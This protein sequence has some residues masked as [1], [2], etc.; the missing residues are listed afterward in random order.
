MKM[1]I[2]VGD[3][4]TFGDVPFKF[5]CTRLTRTDD[6]EIAAFGIEPVSGDMAEIGSLCGR[7]EDIN[8]GRVRYAPKTELPHQ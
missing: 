6:G 2:E 1:E 7:V 8:A 3:I 4:L 5:R